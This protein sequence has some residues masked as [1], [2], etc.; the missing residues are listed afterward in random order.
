MDTATNVH[1]V[2]NA[3]KY[4]LIRLRITIKSTHGGIFHQPDWSALLRLSSS[5]QA[6]QTFSSGSYCGSYARLVLA[7]E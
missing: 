6:S 5:C 7:V 4:E 3:Y 1:C 2:N